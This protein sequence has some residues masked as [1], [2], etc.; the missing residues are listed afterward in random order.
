MRIGCEGFVFTTAAPKVVQRLTGAR[1]ARD[2][3]VEAQRS[4]IPPFLLGRTHREHVNADRGTCGWQE[5]GCRPNQAVPST[6]GLDRTSDGVLVHGEIDLHSARSFAESLHDEARAAT[7]DGFVVDLSG[8]T[9]M[10]STGVVTLIQAVGFDGR[11]VV[12]QSSRQ[13]F[14]LLV[15]VGLADGVMPT[16]EVLP[17]RDNEDPPAEP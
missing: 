6:W 14:T 8:V 12:I 17:P 15:L 1:G 4:A 16:V 11:H 9:F 3:L 7:G 5:R 2:R 13:I 10:D